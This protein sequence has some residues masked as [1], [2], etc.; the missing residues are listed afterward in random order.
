VD[1]VVPAASIRMEV[2]GTPWCGGA[3]ANHVGS[4]FGSCLR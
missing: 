1:E 4:N 3:Y 2:T